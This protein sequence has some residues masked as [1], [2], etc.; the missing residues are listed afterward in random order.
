MNGKKQHPVKAKMENITC[1]KIAREVIF[2]QM[3]KSRSEK[4]YG[5]M[6]AKAGFKKF[7][8]ADVAAMIK[9]FTQLN[10]EVVPGKSV[11]AP[12]DAHTLKIQ[13]KFKALLVVNPI[14]GKRN[15]DIKRRTC[16]NGSKQR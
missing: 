7:G 8:Q 2:T 5:Q 6:S 9:K 4:K 15:G 13:E 10:E 3:A 14:K 12:V 11:V 16:I 1:M